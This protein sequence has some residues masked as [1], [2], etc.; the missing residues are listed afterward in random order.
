MCYLTARKISTVFFK[1]NAVSKILPIQLQ[2][3]NGI[4]HDA[5]T[6]WCQY[7]SLVF[8][9]LKPKADSEVSGLRL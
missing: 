8:N 4:Y 9:V 7:A 2:D 1:A 3:I 6:I 5:V